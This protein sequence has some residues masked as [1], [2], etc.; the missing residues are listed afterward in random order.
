MKWQAALLRWYRKNRRDLPWRNTKDPY[1]IWLSEVMLQQTTVETVIPYY[2]RFLKRF[3]TLKSVALSPEEELLKYWAGLG[4]YNRIRQFQRAAQEIK[5]RHNGEV[6]NDFKT[7]ISLPGFGPYTASAVASIA[8]G[9]PCAVVD[10]NV[11]RVISRVMNYAQDITSAQ[12]KKFFQETAQSLLD[13]KNAS[14]FNQ[15]M[16]ELGATVCTPRNPSCPRC[17]LKKMCRAFAKG[18]APLLPVKLKKMVYRRENSLCLIYRHQVEVLLRK[19]E[20][21]E[22]LAGMWEFPTRMLDQ[23]LRRPR[24]R[25]LCERLDQRL[26]RPRDRELC[27]RLDQP[28][29]E[30][31]PSLKTISHAIMNRRIKVAPQLIEVVQ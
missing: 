7:L 22:I 15:A 25:E 9:L 11:I 30:T 27:E 23:R 29:K 10:G 26:R 21:G 6:P 5:A 20:A 1:A 16:M 8:F 2:H 24:D 28:G 13:Q 4:Y 19:R 12:S 18:N 3:S 17:P 14:D 31:L